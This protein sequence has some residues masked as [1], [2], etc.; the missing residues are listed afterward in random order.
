MEKERRLR[1]RLYWRARLPADAAADV[2]RYTEHKGLL[3]PTTSL[4]SFTSLVFTWFYR[5]RLSLSILF[6]LSLFFL[7]THPS[8]THHRAITGIL[9]R[10]FPPNFFHVCLILPAPCLT[11]PR[12]GVFARGARPQQHL[13]AAA[14][15][16]GRVW[17]GAAGQLRA[18]AA[19]GAARDGGPGGGERPRR[20]AGTHKLMRIRILPLLIPIN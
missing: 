4:S 16:G 5:P 1:A 11:G 12:A 6:L 7:S 3:S 13:P 19:G 2:R 18:A 9:A 17:G 8:Y 10:F 14:V 20:R 15:G